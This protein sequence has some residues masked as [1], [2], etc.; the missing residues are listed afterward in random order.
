VVSSIYRLLP[1]AISGMPIGGKQSQ[2]IKEES[3]P[4]PETNPPTALPTLEEWQQSQDETVSVD[5]NVSAILGI[6]QRMLVGISS[7]LILI[8]LIPFHNLTFL[9][10]AFGVLVAAKIESDHLAQA[11]RASALAAEA[12]RCTISANAWEA[13]SA[14]CAAVA[15]SEA[16]I[17]AN[18]PCP[19]WHDPDVTTCLALENG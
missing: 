4:L 19:L 13:E 17:K 12:Q 15:A 3:S 10:T 16:A 8:N 14:S 1:F 2:N 9:T 6:H 7:H 11:A 18:S 5:S